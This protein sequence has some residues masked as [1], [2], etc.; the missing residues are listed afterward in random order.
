MTKNESLIIK[1]LFFS[2]HEGK[3]L[4]DV[5]PNAKPFSVIHSF[6]GE[7]ILDESQHLLIWCKDYSY[8][9]RMEVSQPI[10]QDVKI[11]TI[12]LLDYISFEDSI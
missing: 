6:D 5:I 7:D 2:Q 9:I 4:S 3:R 1:A 8:D 10:G 12:N 11:I